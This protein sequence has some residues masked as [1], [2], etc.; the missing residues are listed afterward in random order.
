MLGGLSD[1]HRLRRIIVDEAH[2]LACN[3][4]LNEGFRPKLLRALRDLRGQH[5]D[6]PVLLLSATVPPALA[7]TLQA[8]AGLPDLLVVRA[9]ST[10]PNVRLT[11]VTASSSHE[12]VVEA[13]AVAEA[14]HHTSRCKP[15]DRVLVLVRSVA[16]VARVA[17]DLRHELRKSDVTVHEYNGKLDSEAQLASATAWAAKT[18]AASVMV[19]TSGFGTGVDYAH[20][21]AVV[22]V[23]GAYSV[24]DL[25]QELGR[26]GR[27][28]AEAVHVLVAP[29]PSQ[30]PSAFASAPASAPAS[31]SDG[32]AA[33]EAYVAT[34]ECRGQFL[35]KEIDGVAGVD[36]VL[37]GRLLC[38]RC[39]ASYPESERGAH[40]AHDGEESDT[41][42]G[43][44]EDSDRAGANDEA[45]TEKR[46]GDAS[47]VIVRRVERVRGA[48][49]GPSGSGSAGWVG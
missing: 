17:S 21:R 11:V 27:D 34:R 16:A 42:L 2:Q 46:D 7:Q 6:V 12:T 26:G 15:Q 47:S 38:D 4:V 1:Q 28:L 30:R 45:E 44:T 19:A 20:V 18:G 25:V 37:G 40:D 8:E 31:A 14:V 43:A 9:P 22:H 33:V 5:A 39:A 35:A 32:S 49:P 13:C 10:R 3:S 23:G 29:P 48:G 24:L 41:E 36:C